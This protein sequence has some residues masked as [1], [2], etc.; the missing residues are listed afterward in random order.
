MLSAI[1]IMRVICMMS[2]VK[3]LVSVRYVIDSTMAAAATSRS[4][5]TV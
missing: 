4:R 3:I 5:M 2:L 1:D